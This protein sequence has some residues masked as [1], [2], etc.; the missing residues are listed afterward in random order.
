MI[1]TVIVGNLI[2]SASLLGLFSELVDPL[3]ECFADT[4]VARFLCFRHALLACI[5]C[6]FLFFLLLRCLSFERG[7]LLLQLFDL[8]AFQGLS[9]FHSLLLLL[10]A[11]GFGEGA[12][13]DQIAPTTVGHDLSASSGVGLTPGCG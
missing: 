1:T 10:L 9:F 12:L 5:L 6:H 11:T 7:M 8:P 13:S 4:C 3:K 2:D